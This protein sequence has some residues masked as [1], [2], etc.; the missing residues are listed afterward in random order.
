VG[1][2]VPDDGVAEFVVGR[3]VFLFLRQLARFLLGTDG[4]FLYGVDQIALRDGRVAALGG[5][6]RRFVHDVL[7]IRS[8]EPD[9]LLGDIV[10]MHV[11]RYLLI[12]PVHFQNEFA[13]GQVG[14]V[15]DTRRS[16]ASGRSSAISSTSGRLVAAITI[17][18]VPVSKPSISVRIWFKVCSRSSCPPPNPAPPRWRPTASIRR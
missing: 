8:G 13:R 12:A 18:L 4:H 11:L 14:L 2:E 1:A 7:Q 16:K 6:D 5:E 15:D 17:T 10:E 3:D 9:G